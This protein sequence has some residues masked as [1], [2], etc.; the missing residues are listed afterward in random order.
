MGGISYV[1]VTALVGLLRLDLLEAPEAQLHGLPDPTTH[2]ALNRGPYYPEKSR[3]KRGSPCSLTQ[4][5]R[6]HGGV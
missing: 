6:D 3:N 1:R 4:A 2:M 5:S